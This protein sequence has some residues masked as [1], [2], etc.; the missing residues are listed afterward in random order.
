MP[1]KHNGQVIAIGL[2]LVALVSA[3]YAEPE[4]VREQE[5]I[6]QQEQ[7]HERIQT[8]ERERS[9]ERQQNQERQRNMTAPDVS[10]PQGYGMGHGSPRTRSGAGM[11]RGGGRG[12]R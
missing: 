5:R 10:P 1:K 2:F 12:G 8:Q 4:P 3:A 11:P 6:Q 7:E 9:V